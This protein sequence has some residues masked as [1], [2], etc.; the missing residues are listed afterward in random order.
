MLT[1]FIMEMKTWCNRIALI[2]SSYAYLFSF[3]MLTKKIKKRL[4]FL[5]IEEYLNK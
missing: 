4:Q 1:L 3:A 2:H 5:L